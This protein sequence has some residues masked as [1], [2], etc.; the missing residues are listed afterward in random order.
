VK[1]RIL[2]WFAVV[3]FLAVTVLAAGGVASAGGSSWSLDREHYQPGDTAFAWAA[4]A[5]A[6]NPSLGT[7]EEG[8]YFASIV[9]FPETP[10]APTSEAIQV[11]VGEVQ[12]FLEP[13]GDGPVRFGPHHAEITFTVPHLPPGRYGL[14]HANAAGKTLADLSGQGL[15]WIDAPVAGPAGAVR[16]VPAFTG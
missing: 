12:V 11:P 10:P 3:A 5:W 9:P 7:P 16:G 1:H 15:F 14:V 13:Y 4:I 2:T 6:H 8:P